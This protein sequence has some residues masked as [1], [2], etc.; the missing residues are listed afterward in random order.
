MQGRREIDVAC[1]MSSIVPLNVNILFLLLKMRP[2]L[3]IFFIM[4][5]DSCVV[6][7]AAM[8]TGGARQQVS[9]QARRSGG[10]SV[11][12]AVIIS[13]L[14]P[15][16][17]VRADDATVGR[18]ITLSAL[19]SRSTDPAY[20]DWV[21]YQE[22]IK[23]WASLP[24]MA[25][26]YLLKG[27]HE[28]AIAV[29][30]H[31]AR[32]PFSYGEHT[33][34]AAMIYNSAIAFDWVR[35]ALPDELGLAIAQ[36]LLEGADH[37]KGGV[38]S[39]SINHNYS[40]VSL[41][42]VAMAALAAYGEGEDINRRAL[43]DLNIVRGALL[44]DNMF[45]ETFRQKEGTWGEGNHYTPFVVFYPF[46]MTL[47]G[48]TTASS[49]DYFDIVRDDYGNFIAPMATFVLANFRPDFTLERIGDVTG[50]VVPRGT[51]LRPLLDLLASEIRNATLQGQ[52]HSFANQLSECYGQDLVPDIY[53]WMMLV[54]YDSHLP[55]IPSYKTLPLVMRFGEN[56]Y[57]H[58]MFRSG[59]DEDATLITFITGDHYT[60]HQHFDKGHFLIYKH[61]GLVIDGGGYSSMYASSWSNYSTRSL[62]HNSVLV[63]D[64][65]EPVKEGV[66]GTK[67]YPDGG[68]RIIR[69]AQS[70]ASWK[71]YKEKGDDFGLNTADVLAFDSG[72]PSGDY[73]YVKSNLT[74]A[75]GDHVVW[76]DRQLLYLPKVDV[77]FVKDRAITDKP[78]DKYWLLHFQERPSVDGKTPEAGVTEYG[79][80]DVVHAERNG[81]LAL[82]G[83]S[84]RYSGSLFV[85]TLLPQKSTLSI[86][87]GPGYEYFNRF[88]KINFAPERPFADNREAGN[89]R[90]E[91]S[92]AKPGAATAFLHAIQVSGSTGGSMVRTQY[93]KSNHGKMEGAFFQS[94][95]NPYIVLFS[96]SLDA[97]GD[98][99]QRAHLPVSYNINSGAAITHILAEL[100]PAK[101]VNVSVAGRR[102]GTFKTSDAGVL[103]F[104]DNG[105]GARRITI[106]E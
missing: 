73:D 39:P 106:E 91:V 82:E 83:R 35:S 31:L 5:T 25:M 97:K 9:E 22:G 80:A 3:V 77:L 11:E 13:T 71:E 41:H 61:G 2:H 30:E 26:Q 62:A 1:D 40:I 103:M 51:F 29:G 27:N 28:I 34:T 67:I 84:I 75:Y 20:G 14:R 37:L 56:S 59:W 76:M 98:K 23:G 104:R 68:E 85:E 43:D 105:S 95:K 86:V 7:A 19:R 36:K 70:L 50:R 17:F 6:S 33:S 53:G 92:P 60:D 88:S 8:P 87:G 66:Q 58:I 12:S 49:T 52:V 42:A 74:N 57:E 47:R 21:D 100:E 38:I 101:K 54:N 24:A 16:L 18:G 44:N 93:V 55:V 102:I 15:R 69:G 45:F 46:L 32:T 89:W 4:L 81:E 10:Q 78:L 48:M 90:M 63:Y 96:A 79:N 72:P 99:F 64:P 94:D 65:A